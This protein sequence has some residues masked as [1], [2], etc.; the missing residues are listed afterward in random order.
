ML[1]RFFMLLL[2]ACL[3][4]SGCAFPTAPTQYQCTY[5]TLFDT[6][7]TITGRASDE[8]IFQAAAKKI[9]DR[10]EEYHRLF[11][12]YKNYPGVN[13]LKTIND[14]AGIAPVKVDPVIISLLLR[15]KEYYDLT[16]GRVNA[17]MG[18]VLTLWHEARSASL[19][20]P[21]SA[22]LPDAAA[23]QEA[24]KH[25][26]WDAII[27][28]EEA[29]TVYISDPLTRLDVGAIAKGWAAEQ[30]AEDAPAGFLI[31][32][33]GN[34]RATS[35]KDENG[36]P[37]KVGIQ[38]PRG[39]DYLHILSLT[40]GSAVT[41]GDYQRTYTVD[42]KA[43][44]HII[45]PDTG[46]PAEF[47]SSVTIVCEDSALADA[48]STALFLMSRE[49]GQALLDRCNAEALWVNT[50]GQQF[51]SPGFHAMIQN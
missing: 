19:D 23:L 48:L 27:I 43:Y 11:D 7:T 14:Q 38:N 40:Q 47:W 28:N 3:L 46:Y 34:V 25:T 18:S 12:I 37:W 4:L 17:A 26:S 36:T 22:Y 50:Q 20:T 33:G 30:T 13:N 6:V 49:N 21:Q 16:D 2:C 1:R 29:C 45:N 41:S 10:L 31:N 9:H 42:G 39:E 32:L 51:S 15:C 5:L 44:H 8:Q 24:A 35:A